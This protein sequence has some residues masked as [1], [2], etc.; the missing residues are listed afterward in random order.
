MPIVLKLFLRVCCGESLILKDRGRTCKSR[1]FG[2]IKGRN[3]NKITHREAPSSSARGFTSLLTIRSL[4]PQ[5]VTGNAL[6]AGF[7]IFLAL[8]TLLPIPAH[9]LEPGRST[10]NVRQA[11]DHF[12]GSNYFNPGVSQPSPAPPGQEP[13]RSRPA[14][15]WR[16]IFGSEWPAWPDVK[17][18]PPGRPPA[19]RV[20]QGALLVTPVGHATFLIQM[21]GVNILTDPMWSER[22]SP[23]SWA[24]PRRHRKPGIRF[25]D[26]PAVDIVLVSHNHY[27]HLDLPTL[28][29]FAEKGVP[30]A[31]VPLGNLALVRGT[32]I[33]SVDELDWWQSVRLSP[34]VMV[35]LVP[36]QHFSARTPWDRDKTLWGGFV[37]SG[38]SGNVYYAGDTG[39][40]PHF[41]EI[42]RRFSPIRVA[43]LPISPF[44]PQ[45]SKEQ[46]HNHRPPIHMEPAE[47]VQAH[48]DL[49]AEVSIAAHF[50]VFQLG[51]DGF[52]DAV[53]D[54]AAAL[55]ERNLKPGAFVAPTL[56]RAIVL[57]KSQVESVGPV[58]FDTSG[59]NR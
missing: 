29:R 49:G 35:T 37:V 11:S 38:P 56:G 2:G 18:F 42:A 40:G 36:A 1:L 16:W 24:G 57:T 21:D 48:V 5:Q 53:N 4:T 8:A 32:G 9:G 33:P 55:K 23:V 22:C 54:L 28:T 50:Q 59:L 6:A 25:E 17:D 31:V 46:P 13:E 34:D 3:E 26:L 41:R 10:E 39:Y 27:D 45:Q 12:D 44:R 30:R 47:A 43:L 51:A 15:I 19:A 58:S 52:S 20:P 14:W 7:I